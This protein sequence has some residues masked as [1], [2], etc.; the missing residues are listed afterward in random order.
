MSEFFPD[1]DLFFFKLKSQNF[2]KIVQRNMNMYENSQYF[3][4]NI[5]AYIY[6]NK[7]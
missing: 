7:S 2:L 1:T 6:R 5:K 3:C 4:H